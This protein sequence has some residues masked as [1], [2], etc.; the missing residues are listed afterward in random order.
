MPTWM[1]WITQHPVFSPSKEI[2]AVFLEY[3][4]NITLEFHFEGLFL[5]ATSGT[6]D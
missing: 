3:I 2:I 5:G 1:S 4:S 6:D